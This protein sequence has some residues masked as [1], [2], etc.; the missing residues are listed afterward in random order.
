MT[1]LQRIDYRPALEDLRQDEQRFLYD[2]FEAYG[3]EML[4]SG[5]VIR[6]EHIDEVEVVPAPRIA[7]LAGVLVKLL[8][9]KNE[10]RYHLG[11][12]YGAREA[13]LPNITW[14]TAK[15][16]LLNV[17]YYASQPIA[18]KGPEDLVPIAEI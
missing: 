11:I 1:H 12:Y 16:V 4:V 7:G 6:W 8:F 10:Q 18:Y 14:D 9:L 3:A 13:I 2:H 5:D 15:Y 17:A